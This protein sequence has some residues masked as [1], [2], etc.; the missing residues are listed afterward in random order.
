M[1]GASV[2]KSV[3]SLER[4]SSPTIA[5]AVVRAASKVIVTVPSFTSTLLAP[6][7]S[8]LARSRISHVGG[9]DAVGAYRRFIEGAVVH[10]LPLVDDDDAVAELLDVA[11]VVG[12]EDDGLAVGA[13]DLADELADVLLGH[14]VQSDRR[15]V[16]EDE[17][18]V[19]QHRAAEVGAHALSK[20][21]LPHRDVHELVDRQNVGEA[22]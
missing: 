8:S 15:L 18:R 16:Q 2:E 13:I 22:L 11:H 4:N 14:H 21:E 12:G 6:A 3:T 10:D 5:A 19:V 9:D 20:A 1:S 7:A 17:V